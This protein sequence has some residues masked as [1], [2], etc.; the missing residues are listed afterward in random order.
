MRQRGIL[1]DAIEVLLKYGR[2]V[3]DHHGGVVC[4]LDK[5]ARRRLER[6]ADADILRRLD[7]RI[8]KSYLVLSED[9]SVVTVGHRHGRLWRH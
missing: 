6:S 8:F 1:P 7:Q 9:G 5:S 2:E 3:H 4:F